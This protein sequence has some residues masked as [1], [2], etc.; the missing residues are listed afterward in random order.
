M[1]LL[2]TLLIALIL[3][4][5]AK[6]QVQMIGDSIL[7][8][9]KNS[10]RSVGD[11]LAQE[12]NQPVMNNARSGAR[13]SAAGL[14]AAFGFD[15]RRQLTPG[16]FTAIVLDGGGNDLMREC[17]CNACGGTLDRLISKDA[18]RGEIPAFILPLARSGVAIYW[19]DYPAVPTGGGPFSPCIDELAVLT[20][21]LQRL[22]DRV[23]RMT[24]VSGK[25][26]MDADNPA[27]YDPDRIHPSPLGAA[28]LARHLAGVMQRR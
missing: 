21:R 22:A 27:H 26:A 10:G 14:G 13:F 23:P 20:D 1:H 28:L 6:A 19:L 25:A 8:W 24:Y 12:L 4:T 18:T 2:K 5:P 15:I 3:A 17:G 7:A 11:A 9:H 16:T